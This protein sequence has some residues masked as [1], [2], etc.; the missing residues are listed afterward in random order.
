MTTYAERMAALGIESRAVW[1]YHAQWLTDGVLGPT[2]G[3]EIIECESAQ[4]GPE[5]VG[6]AFGIWTSYT[7]VESDLALVNW[8]L[9][10]YPSE[11]K[12][13]LGRIEIRRVETPGMLRAD[14][15]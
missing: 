3:M 2:V 9:G 14:T 12:R 7:R 4:I 11:C 5:R 15:E 8:L 1:L 6:P 13:D 10:W